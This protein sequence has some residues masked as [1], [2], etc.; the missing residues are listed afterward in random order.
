M[1]GAI[2]PI[3]CAEETC[4]AQSILAYPGKPPYAAAAFVQKGWLAMS[5]PLDDEVVYLCPACAKD[6]I[7]DAEKELGMP[8]LGA[9]G[10]VSG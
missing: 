3:Q 9:R 10:K 7:S 6:L 1:R 4:E 2:V 8:L 5:T